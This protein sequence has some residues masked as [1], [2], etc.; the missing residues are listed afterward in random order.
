MLKLFCLNFVFVFNTFQ[1]TIL[2]YFISFALRMCFKKHTH[3]LTLNRLDGI[4]MLVVLLLEVY[5][6]LRYNLLCYAQ[7]LR[8]SVYI[9]CHSS[10]HYA[11]IGLVG[12]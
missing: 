1:L 3:T 12:R 9:A 4:G 5:R 10:W 7:A 11:G 2:Q 6:I 8:S